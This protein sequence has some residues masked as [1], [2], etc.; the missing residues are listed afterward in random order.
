MSDR[1]AWQADE[2]LLDGG[3]EETAPGAFEPGLERQLLT[4]ATAGFGAIQQTQA[5]PGR[6]RVLLIQPGWGSSGYYSEAL[7][8]RD[9]PKTWPAG[10][11]NFV[12]HPT[13]SEEAERPERAVEDWAS[14]LITDPVWDPVERGLVAEVQIFPQWQWLLNEE[15]LKQ[16]GLS[17]RA[18]GTVEFGEAEGREGP[19]VTSLAEGISVD[20]VTKAGAGGRV[21]QLIES[22]REALVERQYDR[23]SDGRFGHVPGNHGHSGK[24]DGGDS[25]GGSRDGGPPKGG[26]DSPITL[27][28]SSG[29]PEVDAKRVA[30]LQA[31]LDKIDRDNAAKAA[32]A[33][34]RT[35]TGA[36]DDN[37]VNRRAYVPRAA[38]FDDRDDAM[39]TT[40]TYEEIPT[41]SGN[42][43]A[44]RVA[45]NNDHTYVKSGDQTVV[46]NDGEIEEIERTVDNPLGQG[47]E[48]DENEGSDG[49]LVGPDG[50]HFGSVAHAGGRGNRMAVNIDGEPAFELSPKEARDLLKAHEGMRNSRRL[51]AGNDAVDLISDKHGGVTLRTKGEDGKATKVKL[52]P[53]SAERLTSA[54]SDL[55][56]GIEGEP[57]KVKTSDGTFVAARNG[58][59]EDAVMTLTLPSGQT[60]IFDSQ[61]QQWEL[62][63]ALVDVLNESERRGTGGA[64]TVPL[65]EARNVGA[66]LESRLHLS[67]TQLTDD[68]YGD[69]R[70]TREERIALSGAIGDALA[71]FTGRVEADQPQLYQRGPYDDPGTAVTEPTQLGEAELTANDLRDALCTALKAVHGG[72]DVWVW[73]RD[74]TDSWVVF[75]VEPSAESGQSGTP[76]LYQQTYTVDADTR[77]ITLTG[78]PIAVT[79]T[80]T[81]TPAPKSSDEGATAAVAENDPGTAPTP[82]PQKESEM[83]ELTEEQAQQLVEAATASLTTR[84]EEAMNRLTTAAT[85]IETLTER[86][87]RADARAA[88]S[89]AETQRLRNDNAARAAV[90]EALRDSSL[91]ARSH[92]RV[93]TEVCRDLPTLENGDLDTAALTES[94]TAAINGER[95]Y[96]AGLLEDSGV[97]HVRGLGESRDTKPKPEVD[98]AVITALEESYQAR[99][100][101]PEAAR[102]AALGR[103]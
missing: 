30:A 10:T 6:R 59:G 18:T 25:G 93:T 21:L 12:N 31:K 45:G 1:F 13:A 80:T 68:M 17:I 2:L 8:K 46:L 91:P 55:N 70:L 40:V 33:A 29:D 14:V 85:Q 39:T 24:S 86:V 26:N 62:Q 75:T 77:A 48:D 67:F 52:R 98:P 44:Y 36:V 61:E 51:M 60:L 92:T 19:I 34:E 32:K 76:G 41:K 64:G 95:S 28:I 89:D 74:H 15:F 99:G 22:A 72:K 7:L 90:T 50:Y 4:E 5:I 79:A 56:D 100:F 96:A 87:D 53:S 66:W 3:V 54:I 101:T 9:G 11:Q 84:L 16:V 49:P 83:P 47:G 42:L 103:P 81:Y 78:E 35:R 43:I 27:R 38:A 82:T 23:A 102:A 20:W 69:G 94:I 71:A 73:E 58:E 57:L 63:G 65:R 88:A 37:A 97:G